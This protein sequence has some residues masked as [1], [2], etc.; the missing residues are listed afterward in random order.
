MGRSARSA[1]GRSVG[2]PE[3]PRIPVPVWRK[4]ACRWSSTTST[5]FVPALVIIFTVPALGVIIFIVRT[6]AVITLPVPALAIVFIVPAL[7]VVVFILPALAVVVFI[8]P[9]LA[10]IVFTAPALAV[11]VIFFFVASKVTLQPGCRS[12]ISIV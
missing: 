1:R 5:W 3:L 7:A 4:R 10:V 11:I 12:K 2:R 6:L 9:V 8:V